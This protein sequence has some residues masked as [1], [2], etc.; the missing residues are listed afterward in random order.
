M[1][2]EEDETPVRRAIREGVGLPQEKVTLLV[3]RFEAKVLK[4]QA[5]LIA[6][7][8]ML[9]A[10]NRSEWLSIKS[11][12]E[13]G[14]TPAEAV[15]RIWDSCGD[16][17]VRPSHKALAGQSVGLNECFV[18]PITGAKMMY[19]GDTSL[20]ASDDEVEGCRCRVRHEVDWCYQLRKEEAERKTTL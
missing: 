14:D 6:Q 18:S 2:K 12:F 13:T 11:A 5:D 16:A 8:E 9:A 20:G 3:N 19:P 15:S 7:T 10:M 17:K 1:G 4:Q